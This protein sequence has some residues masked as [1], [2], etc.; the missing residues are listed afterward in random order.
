MRTSFREKSQQ[1]NRT[2]QLSQTEAGKQRTRVALTFS[3]IFRPHC[4]CSNN[5]IEPLRSKSWSYMKEQNDLGTTWRSRRAASRAS[6]SSSTRAT[7]SA[8]QVHFGAWR[9]QWHVLRCSTCTCPNTEKKS[10]RNPEFLREC[11]AATTRAPLLFS[12]LH[13]AF[14]FWQQS[15]LVQLLPLKKFAFPYPVF[16]CMDA[17]FLDKVNE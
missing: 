16:T 14:S 4:S 11:R 10:L 8:L 5:G 17:C 3:P 12:E 1:L 15:A 2:S 6:I 7:H 9:A 13:S